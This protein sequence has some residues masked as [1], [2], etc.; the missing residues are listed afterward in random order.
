MPESIGP[1]ESLP[2]ADAE[3]FANVTADFIFGTLA[4]DEQRIEA[5]HARSRG[6]RHDCRISPRDPAPNLPVGVEVTVGS[7]TTVTAIEVSWSMDGSEPD[8]FSSAIS[9]VAADV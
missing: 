9:M 5:L 6:L 2:G 3:S 8:D 4:T 7:D 1:A